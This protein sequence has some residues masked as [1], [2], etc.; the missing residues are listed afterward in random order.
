[1]SLPFDPLSALESAFDLGKTA[2]ERIWPDPIKRAEEFRKLEELKQKGDLVALNAEVQLIVGQIAI[3]KEE[4]K[5]P[6]LFVAG[7]RP[8]VGWIGVVALGYQFVLYQFLMWIWSCLE[9]SGSI[10]VGVSPPPVMDTS[11]LL[12]M[13]TGMLGLRSWEKH[14]GVDTSKV[15]SK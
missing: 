8:A 14:K 12:T 15:G 13:I 9:A 6:S 11:A 1:M 2:V 10:P 5:H 7:W 4:A 3:N